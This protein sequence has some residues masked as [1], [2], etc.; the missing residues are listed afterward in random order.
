MSESHVYTFDIEVYDLNI[1]DDWRQGKYL[2]HGYEDVLWTD[3]LEAAVEVIRESCEE[4]L[5]S[6]P[7]IILQEQFDNLIEILRD[8]KEGVR[9]RSGQPNFPL[10]TDYAKKI[11]KTLGLK[12]GGGD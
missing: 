11:V 5:S 6:D 4:C 1:K 9:Y 10:P 3:D 12:V 2:V 8:F 7:K